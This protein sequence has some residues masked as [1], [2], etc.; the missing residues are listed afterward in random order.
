MIHCGYVSA[1]G[2]DATIWQDNSDAKFWAEH[3][4]VAFAY[5]TTVQSATSI[6]ALARC[7]TSNTAF[8]RPASR[9]TRSRKSMSGQLGREIGGRLVQDHHLRIQHQYATD[10]EHFPLTAAELVCAPHTSAIRCAIAERSR[11]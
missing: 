1:L 10:G 9:R 2:L 5:M 7:S 3:Q 8:H 4:N 6:A 11:R